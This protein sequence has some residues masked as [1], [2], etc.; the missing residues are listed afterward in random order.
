M[1]K[2]IALLSATI[3][4]GCADTGPQQIGKD[5]YAISVRVPFS[6][7]SGAKG[8]ALEEANAFCARQH[9]QVLLDHENSYECAL[10]GGCGEAEITFLCLTADD[11]R[12]NPPHE[13]RNDNGVST[14][15]SR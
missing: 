2:A 6:G 3:L 8:Q 7:P 10:H 1:T 14:N 4:V 15:E 5:T 12:Y 11:P 13:M 9:R